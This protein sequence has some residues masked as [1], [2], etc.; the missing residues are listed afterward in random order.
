MANQPAAPESEPAPKSGK[1]SLIVTLIIAICGI[2]GGVATPFAV[3][4]FSKMKQE[5]AAMAEPDLDEE[6]AYIPF[7]EV[8][9]NLD[10]ARFSR[11][12]RLSFSL[13]VA[14]SQKAEI[15]LMV[16]EK[17]VVFTNWIQIQMAEK[18]TEDLK[19]KFGRN[20]V[21]REL[22]DYFNEVLFDDGVERIQ[23]I[24]FNEFHVQ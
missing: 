13:Q 10:E 15:E 21:R 11:F 22:Q 2:A 6:V 4:E 19:G 12:L 24:L 1:L 9:V 17:T 3:A 8:T 5:P 20:R 18:G 16:K 23:D 7:E 14:K